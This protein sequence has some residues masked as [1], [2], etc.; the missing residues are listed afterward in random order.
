MND[1]FAA[2]KPELEAL[3]GQ[4]KKSMAGVM[5]GS[6]A[7]AVFS[8][9]VMGAF[10]GPVNFLKLV[11]AAGWTAAGAFAFYSYFRT[12]FGKTFKARVIKQL[13]ALIDP[14]LRYHPT[15]GLKP[16]AYTHSKLYPSTYS[17]FRAEDLVFGQLDG[18]KFGFCELQVTQA[19]GR[20]SVA[21]FRGLFFEI[22]LASPMPSRVSLIPDFSKRPFSVV[23]RVLE[24]RDTVPPGQRVGF[25]DPEFEAL[26]EVY[27]Q[28][29]EVARRVLSAA[30]RRRLVAFYQK[31]GGDVSIAFVK[32]K[33]YVG[34]AQSRNHFEPPIF[35]SLLDPKP[36]EAFIESLQLVVSVV[37]DLNPTAAARRATAEG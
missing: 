22:G 27:A 6:T 24:G 4:R 35:K 14:S 12:R 7:I 23:G 21:L 3:E 34:V 19:S 25:E 31:A 29:E 9:G 36:F 5:A 33:L 15:S 2:L 18:C 1:F 13:V 32:N 11:M 20:S 17:S 10:T 37:N 26:Y 16:E 28:E 8:F 30:M